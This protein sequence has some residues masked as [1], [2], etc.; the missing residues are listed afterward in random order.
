MNGLLARSGQQIKFDGGFLVGYFKLPIGAA[1]TVIVPSCQGDYLVLSIP[2]DRIQG[3]LTGKF[4]LS[5]LTKAFWGFISNKIQKT[6]VPQL[7]QLGMSAH[8]VS[9]DRRRDEYG[10]VGVIFISLEALNAWLSVQHPRLQLKLLGVHFHEHGA[11]I[12][13]DLLTH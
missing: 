11:R 12:E 4:L 8:T 13:G 3:D 7:L 10:D 2:F 5:R 1:T 6:V 9:V